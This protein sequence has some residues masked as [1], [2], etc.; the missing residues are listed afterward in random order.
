MPIIEPDTAP[1]P[2]AAPRPRPAES[3]TPGP[4]TA[5]RAEQLV[6]T[7]RNSLELAKQLAPEDQTVQTR[8]DVSPTKWHLAHTTWF[9]ET[10]ILKPHFKGYTPLNERYDY[11]FNSYYNAVGPQFHRPSRGDLSRPTLAEVLDYRHHVDHA[12]E[13]WLADVDE[14]TRHDTAFVLETGIHHEQQHQELILMDIKDVLS[15]NPLDPAPFAARHATD[16]RSDKT[17]D[18]DVKWIPFGEGLRQCGA[19]V[20]APGFVYDNEQPRHKTYIHAFHLANRPVTNADYLQFIH[21]GGYETPLLWLSDGWAW[22]QAENISAPLYW[23]LEDTGWTT[24]TLAGRTSLNLSAPVTHLSLYEAHAFAAW[25]GARLPTEFEWETAALSAAAPPEN[26]GNQYD[27]TKIGKQLVSPDPQPAQGI[28]GKKLHAMFGDVWEW[29]SSAYAPYPGFRQE[30]GALGEYN[31]KFMI[32][33]YVLRGGGCATPRG[34]ARATY[35]NFFPAHTRWH[36][37]G[38][39][40]AK[41]AV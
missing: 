18:T 41:D 16:P 13:R 33:Q 31:G 4:D 8:P 32:N 9:F 35:R 30:N 39:R 14:K 12:L 34:H 24:Y 10:F 25:A 1:E 7:R 28:N 19:P 40:L 3:A 27:F 23:R 15:N 26:S 38:L 2:S 29:T 11:L 21:D 36:F 17:S 37:S 22:R 20:P 5:T 6:R